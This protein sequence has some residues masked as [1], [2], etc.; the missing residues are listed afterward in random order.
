MVGREKGY[1]SSSSSS[2]LK[3]FSHT[4]LHTAVEDRGEMYLGQVLRERI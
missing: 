1:S 2:K 3:A 4:S